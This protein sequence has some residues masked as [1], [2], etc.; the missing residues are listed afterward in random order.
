MGQNLQ[1]CNEYGH[2]LEDIRLNECVGISKKEKFSDGRFWP[3]LLFANGTQ[4][5]GVGH[6]TCI[7]LQNSW[8]GL[9]NCLQMRKLRPR[10]YEHLIQGHVLGFWGGG[11]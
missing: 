2:G 8:E 4:A 1:R 5:P 3:F 10:K 11:I 7:I 6:H 9:V